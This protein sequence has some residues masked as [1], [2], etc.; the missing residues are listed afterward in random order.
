MDKRI[1]LDVECKNDDCNDELQEIWEEEM[2]CATCS[3]NDMC[4]YYNKIKRIDF[5]R[6]IFKI[7][8]SCSRKLTREKEKAIQPMKSETEENE[9]EDEDEE[10]Y[11][12]YTIEVRG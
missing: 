7:D 11:G 6:Q 9:N 3:I 1:N 10:P 5:N 12:S 2:P 8:I 4:K